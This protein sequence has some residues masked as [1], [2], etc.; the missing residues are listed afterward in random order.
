M[1]E[2]QF[3]AQVY[4]LATLR[5][6]LFVHFRPARTAHGW[7]TPVEGTLGAGFP[8]LILAQPRTGRLLFVEL[9]SDKG[10]LSP[11]QGEVHAILRAAGADVRVWRP[12]DFDAIA[13]DLAS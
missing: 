3:A 12:S 11:S 6:W 9:K 8:D 2:T 1:N 10:R 7:R 5:G 4:D 13:E